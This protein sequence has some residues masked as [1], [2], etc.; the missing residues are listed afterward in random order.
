MQVGNIWWGT[1]IEAWLPASLELRAHASVPHCRQMDL[2][3]DVLLP[4]QV[5]PRGG[6]PKQAKSLHYFGRYHGIS[7]SHFDIRLAQDA[8]RRYH[9]G[10]D[11]RAKSAT[12]SFGAITLG[13]ERER[14]QSIFIL[15]GFRGSEF[16]GCQCPFPLGGAIADN[17]VLSC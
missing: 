14:S 13:P 5:V 2:L 15:K 10:P 9:V 16:H 12:D 8:G 1:S 3:P 6:P 7:H 4:K 17:S 11:K